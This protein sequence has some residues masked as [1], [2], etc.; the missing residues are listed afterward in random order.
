MR[1]DLNE[2]KNFLELELKRKIEINPQYSK[3]SFARDIGISSTT[4]NEFLSG[5]RELSFKNINAIFKYLNSTIHCSWCD[6][7]QKEVTYLIGGPRSQFICN[8][9]VQKCIDLA[10]NGT[11]MKV[12][13]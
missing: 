1:T 10:K 13:R 12:N 8:E 6:N 7:E 3:N 11:L 5:R 9:Y 2:L 4:L